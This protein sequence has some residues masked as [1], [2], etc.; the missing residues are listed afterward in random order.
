MGI[1]C[2]V[3][4][5]TDECSPLLK[6]LAPWFSGWVQPTRPDKPADSLRSAACFLGLK[7]AN[8]PG[9]AWFEALGA[10]ITFGAEDLLLRASWVACDEQ[11]RMLRPDTAPQNQPTGRWYHSLGGYK[12]I[13]Q[14]EGKAS[15]LETIKTFPPHEHWGEPAESCMPQGLPD[16]LEKAL[17]QAGSRSSRLIV[18][19]PAAQAGVF[20]KKTGYM[21]AGI[22]LML[23]LG[24]AVGLKPVKP[25]RATGETDTD[26]A[27]KCRAALCCAQK[28]EFVYL[29]LNGADEASHRKDPAEKRCFLEKAAFQCL[30]PLLKSNVAVRITADHATSPVT[31]K[32]LPLWQPV[33]QNTA[34]G[35]KSPQKAW[36]PQAL[37][38]F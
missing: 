5:M 25:L 12:A 33:W 11:G 8:L 4:G 35:Q 36:Q 27:A 14:V 23:G 20:A 32:H 30:I 29:H 28:G 9:R 10:G 2:V 1:F 13:V 22:D 37:C 31:G 15:L 3:D 34:A 19:A 17:R 16:D 6:S 7:E 18:W 24:C 21:V 26:L 38:L